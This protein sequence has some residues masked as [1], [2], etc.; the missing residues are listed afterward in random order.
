MHTAT[1]Q[2]LSL[3]HIFS[4]SG[5]H[6]NSHEGPRSPNGGRVGYADALARECNNPWAAAYV[7]EI[8]QQDPD[9]LSK[10]FEDV[11]KRQVTIMMAA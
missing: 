2:R 3:I 1:L 6:G 8:M 10:A 11:Y 9:I 5:G 7:H 4:K